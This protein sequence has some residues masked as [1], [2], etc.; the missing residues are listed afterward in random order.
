MTKVNL[1]QE[2]ENM[3]KELSQE[4]QTALDSVKGY[5]EGVAAEERKILQDVGLDAELAEADNRKSAALE[6][7]QYLNKYGNCINLHQIQAICEKYALRCLPIKYFK[8]N[9]G[10]LVASDIKKFVEK[11]GL[12][13]ELRSGNLKRCLY[14][15]APAESFALSERP[16]DPILLYC[17][18]KYVKGE[19]VYTVVSKWGTDF[20]LKRRLNGLVY[21]R[22]FH[23]RVMLYMAAFATLYLLGCIIM[24]FESLSNPQAVSSIANTSGIHIGFLTLLSL[25][26]LAL[27]SKNCDYLDSTYHHTFSEYRN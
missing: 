24:T 18:N 15:I 1:L 14:V 12:E 16:K 17:P 6:R 2:I 25:P 20:T 19:S 26:L 3:S 5:L 10:P 9:V 22:F 7:Q 23:S 13:A 4:S 21:L 8:G 27:F 11:H